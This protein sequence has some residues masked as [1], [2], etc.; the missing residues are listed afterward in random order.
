MGKYSKA[1]L[2]KE[3]WLYISLYYSTD[4]SLDLAILVLLCVLA[5]P[6]VPASINGVY[7]AGCTALNGILYLILTFHSI[8][9]L[10]VNVLRGEV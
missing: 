3:T 7:C 2:V 8:V 10:V 4:W 1:F 9:I 5:G 6:E